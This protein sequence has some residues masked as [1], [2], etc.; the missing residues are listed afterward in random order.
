MG[1]VCHLPYK[2]TLNVDKYTIHGSYR[3]GNFEGLPLIIRATYVL[4][5]E[6]PRTFEPQKSRFKDLFNNLLARWKYHLN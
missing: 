4:K 3:Y 6:N 5:N 2:S 1:L